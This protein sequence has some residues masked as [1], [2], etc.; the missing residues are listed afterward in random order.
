MQTFILTMLITFPPDG[1]P[2]ASTELAAPQHI[3]AHGKPIDVARSGEASPWLE[4]FD[5]DG[6]NDLLVG[7]ARGGR[8]RIYRNNGTNTEP[9]FGD[10]EWFKAGGEVVCIPDS[11]GDH[12]GFK[13]VMVDLD[14][15]GLIDMVTAT[16]DLWRGRLSELLWFRRLKDG[17]FAKAV[18]LC[19]SDGEPIQGKNDIPPS[20]ADWDGDGLIDI[21]I[22]SLGGGVKLLKNVGSVSAPQFAEAVFLTSA[23]QPINPLWAQ[24][25][26]TD[27]DLDGL[28]DLLV[29]AT[30]GSVV[31]YRNQGSRTNP[32]LNGFVT[33]VPKSPVQREDDKVSPPGQPGW[34]ASVSVADYNSDGL[35]DLLLGDCSGWFQGMPPLNPHEVTRAARSQAQFEEAR[36]EWSK[37]F[38]QYSLL[39]ST[40]PESEERSTAETNST[41]SVSLRENINQLSAQITAAQ[42]GIAYDGP[43][44]QMH[45][46]VWVFLRKTVAE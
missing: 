28:P 39:A 2:Y 36:A 32:Q 25:C 18:K 23:G 30:D 46:F 14:Q 21:I 37:V 3:L 35:P 6:L 26:V 15:D 41:T 38:R 24:P 8:L 9:K 1:E 5:G 27:W 43:Q 44:Y 4:D 17:T 10:Y 7:E 13:P 45:G 40:T 11:P 34:H 29:A 42:E 22:G 19:G 20:C 12:M 16:T 31:C 33:L